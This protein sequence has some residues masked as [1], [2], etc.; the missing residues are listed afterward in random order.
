MKMIENDEIS[1]TDEKEF[2]LFLKYPF[3]FVCA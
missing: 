1:K 2:N 3:L